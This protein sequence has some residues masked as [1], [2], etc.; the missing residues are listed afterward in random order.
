MPLRSKA[1]PYRNLSSPPG[2]HGHVG[3]N[4]DSQIGSFFL[5]NEI[6]F[7]F[8]HLYFQLMQHHSLNSKWQQLSSGQWNKTFKILDHETLWTGVRPFRCN[9]HNHDNNNSN[10][11]SN[12][13]SDNSETKT[14]SATV[15][16][17][18]KQ[19]HS[20][21]VVPILRLRCN[22]IPVQKGC[23]ESF[24]GDLVIIISDPD[25]SCTI[26]A[27][28][29]RHSLCCPAPFSYFVQQKGYFHPFPLTVGIFIPS[30]FFV[31]MCQ[32]LV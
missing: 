10:S 18:C 26:I 32:C 21:K 24:S 15:T 29:T 5:I 31:I 6:F 8:V 13:N 25:N 3:I 17:T 27:M 16:A 28:I 19:A 30:H 4:F 22:L 11:K 23:L 12:N 9:N 2:H 1:G 7:S 20:K 14:L